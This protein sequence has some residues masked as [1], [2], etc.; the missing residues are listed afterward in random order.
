M[1]TRLGRQLQ[2]PTPKTPGSGAV[3]KN[4][5]D[6]RSR[7]SKEPIT[8]PSKPT[9]KKIKAGKIKKS[10]QKQK[11]VSSVSSIQKHMTPVSE[12]KFRTGDA[13][14][15]HERRQ[16]QAAQAALGAPVFT[17]PAVATPGLTYVH[18]ACEHEV[19][20]INMMST[21]NITSD[22]SNVVA[23]G[24]PRVMLILE[25]RWCQV[26]VRARAVSIQQG[27][28]EA[29]TNEIPLEHPDVVHRVMKERSREEGICRGR[30][31]ALVTPLADYAGR[32][33]QQAFARI[34]V[35]S[36][37]DR[38]VRDGMGESQIQMQRFV[39]LHRA[40][41]EGVAEGRALQAEQ[42]KSALEIQNP[43][44]RSTM[45]ELCGL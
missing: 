3:S 25:P 1:N 15:A 22:A 14:Q 45:L 43:T 19:D 2:P 4:P 31:Q 36:T 37:R 41:E 7:S 40:F 21:S 13:R 44:G 8:P 24:R 11:Q 33:S 29:R 26:C 27:W 34:G 12:R 32:T 9:D 10:K 35:V 16:A 20:L 5:H 42:E 18:R 23:S 6:T 39:E 28:E 38:M 30:I 17:K